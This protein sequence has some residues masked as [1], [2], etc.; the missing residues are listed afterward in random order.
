M[1]THSSLHNLSLDQKATSDH[2]PESSKTG[3]A[4]FTQS[5]IMYCMFAQSIATILTF[6]FKEEYNMNTFSL[7]ICLK[8][9]NINLV[10]DRGV[11]ESF[12]L[13]IRS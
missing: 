12:S 3:V 13:M 6:I 11:P 1:F 8:E 7:Q 4:P 5:H 9:C 2:R 10:A